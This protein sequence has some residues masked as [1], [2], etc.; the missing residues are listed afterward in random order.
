MAQ[1]Q[2]Q[3]PTKMEES[4]ETSSIE[5]TTTMSKLNAQAP[6][7]VPRSQ[8]QTTVPGIVYPCFHVVGGDGAQICYFPEHDL[9]SAQN[10]C[11][12]LAFVPSSCSRD[13][14]TEDLRQKIVKQ[15]EYQFSTANL[16][17]TDYL[18]KFIN[19]D[20][21]GYVPISVISSFKKIKPLI[22]NSN[23]LL[24]AAIRTST[25]LVVSAD[26]KKV[27]RKHPLT[28]AE[29]E[30]FQ[31]R[32]VIVENLPENY[33]HQNLEKIFNVAGS[34]KNVRICHPPEANSTNSVASRSVKPDVLV[35][36]KLHA[37]VEY[38]TVTQAEKAIAE[39]NDEN[40]RKGLRVRLLL[41]R[42]GDENAKRGCGRGW[43]KC[44]GHG[45]SQKPTGAMSA[46]PN[47]SSH[48]NQA[49]KPPG[50]RMPDG[51]RGFT[52]GRGKPVS[53]RIF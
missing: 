15:V 52:L 36:N 20:P 27:K 7:F 25:K 51:T 43:V 26:G 48:M 12:G 11:S 47:S 40:W 2:M 6:E 31:S 16:A 37:L 14:L 42:S 46:Q 49:N 10:L 23:D 5:K 4:S 45:Q 22:N 32:T 53:P 35:S 39:L 3:R 13:V 30:D 21:E 41:R 24:A 17:C 1:L 38:E 29:I 33:S 19:K 18:M 28:D 50:P 8:S 44:Q 9:L 34:V